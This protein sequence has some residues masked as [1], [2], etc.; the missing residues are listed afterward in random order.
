MIF[1]ITKF[2]EMKIAKL[3]K[4]LTR[5]KLFRN[6]LRQINRIR[7]IVETADLLLEINFD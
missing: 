1:S 4:E 6:K 3:F 5:K 7:E 2:N